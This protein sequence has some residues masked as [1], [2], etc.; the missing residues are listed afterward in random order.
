VAFSAR[1]RSGRQGRLTLASPLPI[2]V[3]P[4]EGRMMTRIARQTL[5]VLDHV[6]LLDRLERE[7]AVDGLTGVASQRRLLELL[8]YELQRHRYFERRLTL[9]LLDVEGLDRI[10]RQYG[11]LY[12][13][14][15]LQRISGLVREVVRPV[16]VVSRY[17]Q[18]EF[19][20]ILPE[21]DQEAGQELA[22]RLRTHFLQ[23]EFAGGAIGVSV[24]LACAR[25]DE[26][27]TAES[28]LRRSEQALYAAKRTEREWQAL[29]PPG[30]RSGAAP[31]TGSSSVS[32]GRVALEAAVQGRHPE[33]H[34]PR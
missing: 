10:N 22:E 4:D 1:L 29:F 19:A 15:L 34:E 16:D 20:V 3:Q 24:G 9:L 21:T 2:S 25:P 32:R 7:E 11:Y 18:D 28:F 14:H 5:L 8:E 33:P 30:T 26:R 13:N 12:G 6:L 17:G 27:L 23:V 31:G